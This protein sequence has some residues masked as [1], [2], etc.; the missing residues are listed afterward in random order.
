MGALGNLRFFG[1]EARRA[2]HSANQPRFG[3]DMAAHHDVFERGHVGKQANVLKRPRN[4][5]LG[6]LVHS[7]GLVGL[8]R[9]LK[10]A[11]VGG[12]QTCQHVEKRGFARA[13]RTNQPI[14]L[15]A[16]DVDAHVAQRLQTAKTLGNARDSKNGFTHV[17]SP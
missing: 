1:F 11:T 10:G 16:F 8:S 13:I 15:T 4:A 5:G 6:H 3:A 9:Q 17:H 7:G 12:V 2:K 14:N